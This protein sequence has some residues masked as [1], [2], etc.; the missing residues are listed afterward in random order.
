[1]GVGAFKLVVGVCDER[2]QVT[3]RS[4]YTVNEVFEY[5]SESEFS[6]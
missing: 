3:V 2:F 4:R 5:E 6:Y 1:M